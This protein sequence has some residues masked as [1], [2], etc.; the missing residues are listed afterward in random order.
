[1]LAL[2]QDIHN[3]LKATALGAKD[4]KPFLRMQNFQE[5]ET[6]LHSEPMQP[7]IH[8]HLFAFGCGFRGTT[9]KVASAR[10]GQR[11]LV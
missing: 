5:S 6:K 9:E 7:Q 10:N 1:L 4:F 11:L 8:M 3:L 2:S